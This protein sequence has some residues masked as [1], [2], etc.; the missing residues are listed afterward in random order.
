MYNYDPYYFQQIFS[1][2]TQR[3]IHLVLSKSCPPGIFGPRRPIGPVG[4]PLRPILIPLG[5]QTT[6]QLQQ[7]SDIIEIGGTPTLLSR[8]RAVR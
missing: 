1:G 3:R 7:L 8:G 2:Y 5:T 6:I 4:R